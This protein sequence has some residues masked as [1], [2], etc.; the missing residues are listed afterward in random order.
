MVVE[1]EKNRCNK[2]EVAW[3]FLARATSMTCKKLQREP[4]KSFK[5]RRGVRTVKDKVTKSRRGD[6]GSRVPRGRQ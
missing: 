4:F 6:G 1:V 2:E 3:A 5:G